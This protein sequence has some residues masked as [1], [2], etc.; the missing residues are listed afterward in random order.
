MTTGSQ[1]SP[2]ERHG[3]YTIWGQV[4][5]RET[6]ES[7]GATVQFSNLWGGNVQMDTD[8]TGEYSL[9]APA[10]VNTGVALELANMTMNFDVVGRPNSLFEVPR[11][12]AS[13]FEAYEDDEPVP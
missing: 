8:A 10:D 4:T 12:P 9:P 3:V 11:A 5:A 6:G 7:W 13:I 2:D 1:E